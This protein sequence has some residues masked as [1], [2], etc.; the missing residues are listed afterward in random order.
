MHVHKKCAFVL[1]NCRSTKKPEKAIFLSNCFQFG[2]GSPDPFEVFGINPNELPDI[3]DEPPFPVIPPP[4]KRLSLK[5]ISKRM[6]QGEQPSTSRAP[7][8]VAKS[9]SSSP[10]SYVAIENVEHLNM[11][12]LHVKAHC[13]LCS[14]DQKSGSVKALSDHA[15]KS[16]AIKI[17]TVPLQTLLSPMKPCNLNMYSDLSSSF[18]IKENGKLQPEISYWQNFQN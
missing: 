11:F 10:T 1:K 14:L 2:S 15:T 12:T 17:W 5:S 16:W 3:P 13:P 7:V 9:G 18:P 6:A 8:T 4:K